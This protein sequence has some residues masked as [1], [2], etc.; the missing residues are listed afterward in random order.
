MNINDGQIRTTN[1]TFYGRLQLPPVQ[2]YESRDKVR[3][4]ELGG[5]SLQSA[6]TRRELVQ[7]AKALRYKRIND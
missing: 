2:V 6:T 3:N 7:I 1:N 4:A 5:I